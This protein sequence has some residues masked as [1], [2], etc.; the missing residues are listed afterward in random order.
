MKAAIFDAPFQMH[1]GPWDQPVPGPDEVAVAVKAAGIC[2]GDMHIY[3]GK[4]PYAEFP[5]IG[6]RNGRNH[7]RESQQ[8]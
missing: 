7:G 3:S 5:I 1:V 8:F 6:V 4:S 2:A